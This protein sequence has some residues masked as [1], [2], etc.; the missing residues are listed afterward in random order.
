[1]YTYDEV[2][3]QTLEYFQ[4][5]DLA[6][7]VWIDKYALRDN[8][9][10]ILEKTPTDMHRRLAK[11]FARIEQK[12]FKKPLH[13]DEIFYL[14]NKFRFIVPQGGILYGLGNPYQYITLSNCYVVKSP[15]DS[16]G[17]ICY[18]DEQILQIS[19]RR[20]GCGTD[21]SLLRPSGSATHNSSK[22]STGPISFAKR[23]S[24][25]I[26]EVGQAGRRGALMLTMDCQHPD[27]FN[28]INCKKDKTKI[29]GANLSVKLHDDFIKQAFSGKKYQ[30]QWP[31][32]SN[33]PKIVQEINAVDLWNEL[34]KAARESAEPGALFWDTILNTNIG[35]CYKDF[36]FGDQSCNPCAELSLPFLDSCRLLLLNLYSYVQNPFTS[37]ALFD[38]DLF[39][40]HARVAQRLM[41]DMIDLE[42]ECIDRIIDKIK[43]DDEEEYIKCREL[44]LWK[45]I[46]YMCGQGRRTGTGTTALADALAA[47]GISY[48]SKKS[49]ETTDSIYETF[50]LACFGSSVE[51]A[52]ELGS[53]PMWNPELEKDNPYLLRLK[54]ISPDLYE[55][56]QKYGRRN[57]G[58]LTQSPAGTVSC[59][60]QTSSGCEP[61]T[62]ISVK[63]RKKG[64]LTDT[65]FRCDFTDQNGDNWM[66]FEYIHPKVKIWQDIT[67]KTD[68]KESPWYGCCA[69]DINYKDRIKIQSTMQKYIDH[70]ISSTINLP[71]NTT[72]E[73]VGEIYKLAWK[74]GLKGITIYRKNCRTGVI[75]DNSKKDDPKRPRELP[76]DVHF[77][78]SGGKP[79]MVLVGLMNNEPYEIFALE[80]SRLSSI[81]QK[82]KTGTII[83]KKKGFYKAIFKDDD[84]EFSPITDFCSDMEEAISRL[85]STSLRAKVDL[86][87]V[88]IQL[89]KTGGTNGSVHSYAKALSRVLKKYIKDGT[90][91]DGELCPDC[92]S[93]LVRKD[94]C[95]AC[96]SES[97]SYSKC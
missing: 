40:Q 17:G 75:L 90:N 61:L 36:G 95:W 18:T 69:E 45:N 22:T 42:L 26:R 73:E 96:A 97:C 1:M 79:Y 52:K 25:S 47:L 38:Y 66:E 48:G 74:S 2:Y 65:N 53:F 83:R 91:I 49:I 86:N 55:E 5:D 68:I 14:L 19:K 77:T 11:E 67:G 78:S 8:K 70:S 23:Y 20:G 39:N 10:N 44:D 85:V 63:R 89:E 58:L 12:K 33:S 56:M 31:I 41:D 37:H 88:T 62:F 64:N 92:Q 80:N 29:T 34:I 15:T 82:I 6:T 43:L 35:N 81:S 50:M 24:N 54:D 27:I 71:E 87:L 32:Q 84:M 13:E 4:N 60:T 57:L 7:K 28:F 21:L 94:G 51:M 9:D 30:L 76:C 93:P 46:K 3:A 72:I 59:E 16:Y